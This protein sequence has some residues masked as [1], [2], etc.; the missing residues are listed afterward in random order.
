MRQRTPGKLQAKAEGPVT[1]LCYRGDNH[2]GAQVMDAQGQLREVAV[3]NLL[4]YRG[5]RGV[6]RPTRVWD[7]PVELRSG[8]SS[9]AGDAIAEEGGHRVDSS[10]G[11]GA[12]VR[13]GASGAR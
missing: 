11:S 2:L 3:A 13:A 7:L 5:D 10:G 12:S 6:D 9:E 1:F 8:G 4:P